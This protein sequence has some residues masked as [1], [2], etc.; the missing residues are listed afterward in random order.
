MSL[1]TLAFT[2][3]CGLMW[4][5]PNSLLNPS[6][7]Y[8]MWRWLLSCSTAEQLP[9]ILPL[10]PPESAI[11]AAHNHQQSRCEF[12]NR[13]F[14]WAVIFCFCQATMMGC[15]SANLCHLTPTQSAQMAPQLPIT[16]PGRRLRLI[17]DATETTS[18]I[19]TAA[20]T[21]LLSR[22]VTSGVP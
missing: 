16:T 5:S 7:C 6:F 3:L 17:F 10:L 1:C 15:S 2:L 4:G 21:V 9:P 18:S 11:I 13:L 8:S 14:C 20:G 19:L 22:T 12:T